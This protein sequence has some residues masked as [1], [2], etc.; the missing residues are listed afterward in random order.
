M[1]IP[2]LTRFKVNPGGMEEAIA[3]SKR[4]KAVFERL[5][6]EYARL[7]TIYSGTWASQLILAVRYSDWETYGGVQA[8]A[9]Q[10]PEYQ[11]LMAE[12]QAGSVGELEGRSIID[13]IDL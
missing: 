2:T 6:A 3:F 4:A 9:R 5:G 13:G 11:S 7:G 1:S 10:D 12:L 8:A